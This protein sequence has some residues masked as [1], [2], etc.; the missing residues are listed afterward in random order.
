MKQEAQ[1]WIHQCKFARRVRENRTR[2]L[3]RLS[4]DA[5]FVW[6]SESVCS[7]PIV[8]VC[9]INWTSNRTIFSNNFTNSKYSVSSKN[10]NVRSNIKVLWF[11]LFI[12]ECLYLCGL[13]EPISEVVEYIWKAVQRFN[14]EGNEHGDEFSE[15]ELYLFRFNFIRHIFV[16]I[17]RVTLRTWLWLNKFILPYP[18]WWANFTRAFQDLW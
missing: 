8:V 10:N 9:N 14:Y 18:V 4:F 3:N 1:L 11:L 12:F 6:G 7:L 13:V 17:N 2:M 15:N 16:G 5:W